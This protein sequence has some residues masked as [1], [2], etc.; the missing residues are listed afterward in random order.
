[1]AD[2]DAELLA[3]AEGD[4]SGDESIASPPTKKSPSP[5]RPTKQPRHSPAPDM[6]RKGTAKPVKRSRRR[7][8]ESDLED[9]LS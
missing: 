5:Q 4:S 6:A 8:D 3:L 1:M 9:I 2:L 7:K